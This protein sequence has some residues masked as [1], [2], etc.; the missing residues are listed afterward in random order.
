MA[1]YLA[2]K[3]ATV[4]ID[5]TTMAV[6]DGSYSTNAGVDEVTNL[7]SGGFYHDVDTIKMSTVSLRCVYDGD[8]PPN[9]DEGDVVALSIAVPNGPGVSGNYR[10]T[11]M[12]WPVVN[13]RAAVKYNFD[14]TSQGVYNKT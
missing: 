2:G 9:F 7:N 6:E 10:I 14:A 12:D 5:G 4:T 11:R 3:N 1:I 8:S 13:V